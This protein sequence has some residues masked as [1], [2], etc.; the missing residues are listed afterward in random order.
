MQNIQYVSKIFRILFQVAFI[1]SPFA[2]MLAWLYAPAPLLLLGGVVKF[3]AIP[4]TYQTSI[5]HALSGS[6]K[7]LGCVL[8]LVAWTIYLA[9]L[10]FLIKLFRLFETGE[11]FTARVVQ[12][13][14][15]ASYMLLLSQVINP[16]YEMLMGLVLTLGNP[17]GYRMIKIMFS[18]HNVSIILIAL[19]ILLVSW[20][21]AEG[22]KLSDE[23]QLVI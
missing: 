12:Y 10:F 4:E 21:M 8:D 17:P 23:Q 7:M 9:L 2:I 22:C 3:S 11:I 5:L 13:I 18:N 15:Q 14:R 6:E 19:M 16:I 20:V 1:V